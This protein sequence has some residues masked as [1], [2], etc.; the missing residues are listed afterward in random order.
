MGRDGAFPKILPDKEQMELPDKAPSSG[1][2]VCPWQREH[3][4]RMFGCSGF[5]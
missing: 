1:F 4:L 5:H 2:G 3:S